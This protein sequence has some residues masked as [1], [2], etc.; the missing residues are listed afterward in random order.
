[1]A[2][3]AASYVAI[4]AREVEMAPGSFLMIHR[5]WTL[6]FGNSEDIRKTADILDKIDE[7]LV[8]TYV[9]ATGQTPEQIREWL[10][11]ETWFTPEESVQHGFA[12]RIAAAS[13]GEA[14]NTWDLSAFNRVPPTAP[15]AAAPKAANDD[16]FAAAHAERVRRAALL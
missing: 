7:S 2:A 1:L 8:A 12:D 16:E 13:S 3:S 9:E 11:A 6:A 15:R 4:A 5:A 10:D 14:S